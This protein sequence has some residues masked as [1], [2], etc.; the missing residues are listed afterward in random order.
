MSLDKSGDTHRITIISPFLHSVLVVIAAL[1][2]NTVF[3]PVQVLDQTS[4]QTSSPDTAEADLIHYGD[5][6]DVDVIGNL[7]H[8]W[9]GTINPEGYLDRL[10][11][12]QEP[13][14]ALC[15]SESD[16]AAEITKQFSRVLRDPKI[17]VKIVDR[18]GRAVTLLLGAVR[19]QQRLRIKREVRLVELISLSGGITDTASGD[20]TIVRPSTLNCSRSSEDDKAGSLVM[21]FTIAQLLNGEAQANPVILSGDIITVADASPIYV[22][23][24]VN[25]PRQ[26]SSRSELTVT[27]AISAAGGLAKEG[28]ESDVTIYRRDGRDSKSLS[29][30]LKKIRSKQQ[31]DVLLKPFDIIDVGQKGRA[32]S[33][34]PPTINAEAVSRDIFKLPVRIVE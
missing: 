10:T 30:D 29:V 31:E 16:V 11:L 19:N 26:I 25:T 3:L 20:I 6:I 27:H 4:P 8:D 14:L 17:D 5:V 24:G 32:R 34:N 15:K 21:R 22:I 1:Y 13:I 9:R 2:I 12:A 7:E 23:G 28:V 18:T 33:K